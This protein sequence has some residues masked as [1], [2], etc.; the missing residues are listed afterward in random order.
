MY[1]WRGPTWGKKVR[2]EMRAASGTVARPS[3]EAM[4]VKSETAAEP[5]WQIMEEIAAAPL[6]TMAASDTAVA[7][8][9]NGDIARSTGNKPPLRLES[10]SRHQTG[11]TGGVVQASSMQFDELY[12][13]LGAGEQAGILDSILDRLAILQ[14]KSSH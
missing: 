7:A 9:A 2:C 11:N 8:V 12:C 10:R 3:R 4:V 13:N 1:A 6:A 5:V 14:E